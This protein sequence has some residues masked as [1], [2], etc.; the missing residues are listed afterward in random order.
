MSEVEF[1]IAAKL[2][3]SPVLSCD[4]TIVFHA[5]R[6]VARLTLTGIRYTSAQ[7]LPEG[8]RRSTSVVGVAPLGLA[9]AGIGGDRRPGYRDDEQVTRAQ[10]DVAIAHLDRQRAVE[11]REG[12]VLAGI[13]M[14]TRGTR[15]LG[16]VEQIPVGL[17]DE[18]LRPLL[19]HGIQLVAQPDSLAHVPTVTASIYSSQW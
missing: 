12:F 13:A 10:F 15:A 16:H 8:G 1:L 9:A 11:E 7:H 18:V 14:R 5:S 17:S 6:L 4:R 3:D 19:G 2:A